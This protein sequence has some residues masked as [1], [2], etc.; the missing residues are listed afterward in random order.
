MDVAPSKVQLPQFRQNTGLTGKG[1]I[2]GV[3]NSG[4][5]AQ[6]P[7][8]AGRILRIREQEYRYANG[9][10]ELHTQEFTGNE[11]TRYRDTE[12]H[13]THVAGIA[14]G[15]DVTFGG[16]A[17]GAE[18]EGYKHAIP[19]HQRGPEFLMAVQDCQ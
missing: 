13:G 10:L 15:D 1:V 12:G 9:R 6:H 8:F 18:R 17:L 14:A 11:L 3:V 4:I 5:D 19:F 2:I 7:A 16:V